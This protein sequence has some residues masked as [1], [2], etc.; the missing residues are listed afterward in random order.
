MENDFKERVVISRQALEKQIRQ[1]LNEMVDRAEGAVQ[2]AQKTMRGGELAIVRE[3]QRLTTLRDG[4]REGFTAKDA[5][6][7][8]Q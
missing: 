6:D 4:L 2:A 7:A 1:L 8:T 3:I 5:A